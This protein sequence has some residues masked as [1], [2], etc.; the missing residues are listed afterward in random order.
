M[1]LQ[2]V[3]WAEHATG[4]QGDTPAGA[5]LDLARGVVNRERL[6]LNLGTAIFALAA[7]SDILDGQIARRWNLTTDFGRIADPFAD[8]VV[9][10]GSFLFLVPVAASGVSAWMVV[11][12]VAR[13]SLVDGLR[14]FAESRGVPFPASFWGKAKMTAQSLCI[15]TILLMLANAPNDPKVRAITI[16]LLALTLLVTVI[17]G[18]SYLVR[19]R[20]LL[21][22]GA[23]GDA[24]GSG[25][26][27]QCISNGLVR[28]GETT[29]P[30]ERPASSRIAA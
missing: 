21:R 1:I 16:A 30:P 7:I 2:L 28:S 19:A 14:G 9:V 29:S 20:T 8:K 24:I 3:G 10:I 27:G 11:V 23:S 4:P 22:R 13:E 26:A 5:L 18:V 6:L 25:R 12:I 15:G 17:S